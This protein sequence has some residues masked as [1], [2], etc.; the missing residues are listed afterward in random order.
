MQHEASMSRFNLALDHCL[1]AM[2]L[3]FFFI[4]CASLAFPLLGGSWAAFVFSP[5]VWAMFFTGFSAAS[6]AGFLLLLFWQ[7][8]VLRKADEQRH[9]WHDQTDTLT[10]VSLP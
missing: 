10:R 4:L 6:L 1:F 9:Q 8:R 7:T 5:S 3:R 2:R